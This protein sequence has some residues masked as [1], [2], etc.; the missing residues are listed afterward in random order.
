MKNCCGAAHTSFFPHLVKVDGSLSTNFPGAAFIYFPLNFMGGP[1]RAFL[2]YRQRSV[3]RYCT[4]FGE[5][6]CFPV[7]QRGRLR[8]KKNVTPSVKVC[9]LPDAPSGE[10]TS[11]GWCMV[12]LLTPPRL[13]T[14]VSFFFESNEF[15]I[16]PSC[17]GETSLTFFP[18]MPALCYPGG[19]FFFL[20]K[21]VRRRAS[22]L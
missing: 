10:I 12:F 5:M 20:N 15:S 1:F 8:E 3:C 11:I 4:L 16:G 6:R 9:A 18:G 14:T 21:W 22:F 13:L 17:S 2:M 7:L 19:F